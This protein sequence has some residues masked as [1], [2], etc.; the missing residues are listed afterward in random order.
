KDRVDPMLALQ[1]TEAVLPSIPR[2]QSAVVTGR[3]T[4]QIDLRGPPSFQTV[5]KLAHAAPE[6]IAPIGI[7]RHAFRGEFEVAGFFHLMGVGDE[8]RTFRSL[9]LKTVNKS[10]DNRR[11]PERTRSGLHSLSCRHTSPPVVR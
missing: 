2:K 6:S 1:K 10:R 11:T 4:V 9:P 7:S 8:K 5:F 3:L